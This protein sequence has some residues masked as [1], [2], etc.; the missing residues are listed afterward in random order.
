MSDYQLRER[1]TTTGDYNFIAGRL[2]FLPLATEVKTDVDIGDGTLGTYELVTGETIGSTGDFY[3]K[4]Q[5]TA[6]RLLNNKGQIVA[7]KKVV[8]GEYDPATGSVTNTI[9]TQAGIGAV[10]VWN[11]RQIDG[12]LIKLGDKRL[13][14]S[15][16]NTDGDVLT[17]PVLGDKVT[18]AAGAVYT[19]VAPLKTIS[20][21][22]TAILYDC[23]MRV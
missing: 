6:N 2:A 20:P 1:S 23:N 8:A 13:L 9:T 12:T 22:G 17:A 3:P 7:L 11:A 15:P 18:D 14:L 4:M 21:A 5:V 10:V 16:L 19:L